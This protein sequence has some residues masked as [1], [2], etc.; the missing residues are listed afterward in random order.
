VI[1]RFLRVLGDFEMRFCEGK[2]YPILDLK[3][4]PEGW[5]D[6]WR[7]LCILVNKNVK[8][9]TKTNIK[10]GMFS[11]CNQ[12]PKQPNMPSQTVNSCL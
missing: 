11:A 3:T 7:A 10:D 8:K 1:L 9:Q 5:K 12:K 4:I 2:F 6:V